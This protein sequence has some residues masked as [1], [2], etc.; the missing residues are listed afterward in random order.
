MLSVLLL[1]VIAMLSLSMSRAFRA[2]AIRTGIYCNQATKKVEAAANAVAAVSYELQLFL[3][4]IVTRI[5]FL[6]R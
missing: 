5:L 3:L 2:G 4:V 1:L 6:C